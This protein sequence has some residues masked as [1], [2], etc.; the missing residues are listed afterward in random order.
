[1]NCGYGRGFSVLE[2]LDA[3]DR[4]TN[5]QDR[6]AAGG[7]PRRAIPTRW[8]PT[9]A[10][11]SRPCPGGPGATIWTRSSPTRWPGSAGWRSGAERRAWP[12]RA[13]SG[14]PGF[15]RRWPPF[16]GGDAEP[17]RARLLRQ[18][19]ADRPPA[20]AALVPDRPGAAAC[21]RRGGEAAALDKA[22]EAEPRT[23]GA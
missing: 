5:L 23:V 3:V 10:G 22:L 7:A 9:I 2:V 11:S 6:A 19:V 8:S 4:V 15:G 14:Q 16:A 17:R 13:G 18:V 1:M 20:A 12:D 21:R